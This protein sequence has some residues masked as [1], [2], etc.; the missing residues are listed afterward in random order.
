LEGLRQGAREGDIN[1]LFSRLSAF[2]VLR[3][4]PVRKQSFVHPLS[5]SLPFCPTQERSFC[6]HGYSQGCELL[7]T[8]SPLKMPPICCQNGF[9]ILGQGDRAVLLSPA[10][11][12]GMFYIMASLSW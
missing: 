6:T 5:P 1:V 4:I 9:A 2:E 8:A 12:T 3:A 10:R 11:T 7:T